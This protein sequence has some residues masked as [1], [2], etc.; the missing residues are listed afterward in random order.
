MKSLSVLCLM[1]LCASARADILVLETGKTLRAKHYDVEGTMIRVDL[2]DNAQIAI[3]IEWVKEIRPS[4]PEPEPAPVES[5]PITVVPNFAYSNLVHSVCKKHEVDWRLIFAVMA[6]ESNFN[7]HALSPKGALGLMQLMP[8]TA[9]LYHVNDPYD[10]V[11]NIDAGVRHLKMLL[12]RYKGKLELVLA[13]YNSGEKVVD[14]YN[15]IPPYRETK[16]YVK[17]VLDVYRGLS[18]AI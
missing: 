8:D 2:N 11:Q 3:P 4:P 13:A 6:A 5:A 14:R 10:P 9:R 18:A 15:G 12:S 17:K 7:P 16:D 1:L